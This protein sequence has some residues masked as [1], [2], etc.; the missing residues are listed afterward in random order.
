M[1]GEP[2]QQRVTRVAPPMAC[3]ARCRQSVVLRRAPSSTTTQ[4]KQRAAQR[5]EHGPAGVDDLNLPV[6]GEGLRV[7]GQAGGVP[8]VVAGELACRQS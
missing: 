3:T 6:A 1:D 5:T 2:G 4:C 8:A 7:G